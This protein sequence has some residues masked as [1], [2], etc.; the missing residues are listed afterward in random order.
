L[1]G[2][3]FRVT[4][5]RG[6]VLELATPVGIRPVLATVH[7]SAVLRAAGE[8]RDE[9]FAGLVADLRTARDAV[10]RLER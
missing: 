9:A 10:T 2:S 3:S 1:L 5:Q 4:K 7:P 6:Q 8:D